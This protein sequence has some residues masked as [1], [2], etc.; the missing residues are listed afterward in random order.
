MP[1][2]FQG[3]IIIKTAID[4]CM[5]DM[6]KNPWLL[7]HM[8][9]DLVTNVYLRD[10]YGQKQIDACKEWFRNNNIPVYMR[11]RNDKDEFPCIT[12][13]MGP[14]PEKEAMKTMADQS[15][16]KVA[17]MPKDIGKPIG[18]VVKPFTIGAYDSDTG[19]IDTDQDI[20]GMDAVVE[21]MI[22]VDPKTGMGYA[23]NDTDGEGIFIEEDMDLSGAT[24]YGILPQFQYYEARIEH[25]FFQETYNIGCHSHGDPQVMLWLWSIAKYAILR[26]RESMLEANGFTESVVSSGNPDINY[27]F[28]TEGGERVWSRYITISGQVENSWIKSPRRFI[29]VALL[30]E[31]FDSENY[32]GGIKILSNLD[33]PSFIKPKEEVWTTKEDDEE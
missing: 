26:Y 19:H 7:D 1:G 12:I 3:D 24:V 15:T 18:Y 31:R 17:L 33:S 16:E 27:D 29:E 8:L 2:I 22:L 21:G 14:S 9:S 13:E 20:L 11:G 4:L 10:K 28:S 23:I 5:E 25:A 30:K 32:A 6:K